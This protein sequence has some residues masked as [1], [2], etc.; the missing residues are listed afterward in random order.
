MEDIYYNIDLYNYIN[1]NEIHYN[2][3][4]TNC[5]TFIK[6]IEENYENTSSKI[7]IIKYINRLF[8]NNYKI[9]DTKSIKI[10]FGNKELYH[11]VNDESSNKLNNNIIIKIEERFGQIYGPNNQNKDIN[12]TRK[13]KNNKNKNRK[14]KNI[15]NKFNEFKIS[16]D[17]KRFIENIKFLKENLCTNITNNKSCYCV[18][19]K[20]IENPSI[21]N[22]TIYMNFSNVDFEIKVN[23]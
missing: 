19:N 13:I 7:K 17:F 5:I 14:F 18:S 11:Y 6:I 2:R 16:K 23:I 10:M 12:N 21:T 9:K 20:N 1:Y 3:K 15:N 22:G 8:Q 4:I